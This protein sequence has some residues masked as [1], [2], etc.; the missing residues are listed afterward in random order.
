VEGPWE[1]TIEQILLVDSWTADPPLDTSGTLEPG[2]YAF[3]AWPLASM[4]NTPCSE[5]QVDSEASVQFEL[6]FGP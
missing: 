2:I 3:Y 4:G 5:C 1:P 6:T